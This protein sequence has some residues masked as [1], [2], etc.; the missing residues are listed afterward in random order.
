MEYLIGFAIGTFMEAGILYAIGLAFGLHLPFQYCCVASLVTRIC[1]CII[2]SLRL[3]WE[4][5]Y[6]NVKHRGSDGR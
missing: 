6:H 3:T 4:E 2:D 1:I 5:A